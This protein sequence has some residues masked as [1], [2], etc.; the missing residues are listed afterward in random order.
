MPLRPVLPALTALLALGL[1]PGCA[2]LQQVF[3]A[4][5]AS[6]AGV[7]LRG[8]DLQGLELVLDVDV[9]NPYAIDLPLLGL[10]YE[11]ARGAGS[12]LKGAA[13]VSGSIPA[14]GSRTLPVSLRLEFAS[15]LALAG[16]I[17]PGA[18]VDYVADI[19]VSVN[20]P[21]LGPLR[22][23]LR[24]EGRFPVPTV[25]EVTL[26]SLRW[27]ELALD[28]ASAEIDIGLRNTNSFGVDLTQFGYELR[29][30]GLHV[31]SSSLQQ[32]LTLASGDT[33]K[34]S[35]Q[36]SLRPADLGFAAF[37]MLA[38]SDASYQLDGRMSLQS[39]F[40][41]LDLPYQR[42]GKIAFGR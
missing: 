33:G 14:G 32:A 42:A 5:R 40:G 4:P 37:K 6:V 15:L 25:P 27:T 16:D 10:D 39:P 22:L 19:G 30:G 3:G 29:I 8:L 24:H 28:Q 13:D 34:L 31:A 7:S 2:Q 1:G 36:L 23:P 41:P 11:I 26:E 38:G 35:L 18:V 21:G 9:S 12:L 17:R 20:A